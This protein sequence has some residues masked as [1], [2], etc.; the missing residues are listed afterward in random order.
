MRAGR[1]ASARNGEVGNLDGAGEFPTSDKCVD[2]GKERSMRESQAGWPASGALFLIRSPDDEVVYTCFRS[3]AR[4]LAPYVKHEALWIEGDVQ[5]TAALAA[6]APSSAI[7]KLF[8]ARSPMI[9][10]VELHLGG[11]A[12]AFVRSGGV[13]PVLYRQSYFDELRI[14]THGPLELTSEQVE[15]IVAE[16]HNSL[17]AVVVT[18]SSPLVNAARK[19]GVPVRTGSTD[20]K[21]MG[22]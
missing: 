7:Q 8:A 13:G 19:I 16:L 5:L 2:W 3:L 20:R 6:P 22:F 10:R 9:T 17:D 11:M 21:A 12:I 14:D 4:R 15:D 18:G 1:L